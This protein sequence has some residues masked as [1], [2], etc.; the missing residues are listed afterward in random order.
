MQASIGQKYQNLQVIERNNSVCV[1]VKSI[2][3]LH[4][5]YIPIGP[6]LIAPSQRDNDTIRCGNA[7]R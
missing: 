5:T 1:S 2:Y 7:D 3:I 6:T 4:K